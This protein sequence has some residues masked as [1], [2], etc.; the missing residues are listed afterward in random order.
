MEPSLQAKI[1]AIVS[2]VMPTAQ[3]RNA[4]RLIR[5]ALDT[6][7]GR[8]WQVIIINGQHW[9]SF[10]HEPGSRFVFQLKSE[11]FVIFRTPRTL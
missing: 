9:S 6:S 1:V 8:L 4:P 11:T 5:Q 7:L 3:A 2:D 10:G